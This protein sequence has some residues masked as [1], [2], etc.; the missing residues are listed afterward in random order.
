MLER[1]VH[2]CLLVIS[3][4]VAG[5]VGQPSRLTE[6]TIELLPLS[7]VTLNGAQQPRHLSGYF[8]VRTRL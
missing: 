1:H 2:R 3:C 6:Q 5:A 7:N 4:I 8:T